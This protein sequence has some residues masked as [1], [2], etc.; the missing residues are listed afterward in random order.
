[1]Q[2]RLGP[3]GGVAALD[4]AGTVPVDPC[5]AEPDGSDDIV[6][7]HDNGQLHYWAMRNGQRLSGHDISTPVDTSWT[8][9]GVGDVSGDGT[10]D[11]VWQHSGG[12]VHYWAL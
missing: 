8:V 2:H 9:R 10:D 12:Q 3:A 1:M 4:V 7:R 11:I 6:W 5:G